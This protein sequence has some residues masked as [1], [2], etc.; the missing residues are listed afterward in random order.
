MPR[1]QNMGSTGSQFALFDLNSP[2]SETNT[3]H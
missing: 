3:N 2:D 1:G